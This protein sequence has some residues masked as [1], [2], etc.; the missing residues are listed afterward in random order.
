MRF[1]IDILCL[2]YLRISA[3]RGYRLHYHNSIIFNYFD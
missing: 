1:F 2:V 3:V